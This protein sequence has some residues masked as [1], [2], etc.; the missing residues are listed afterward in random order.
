M[1]ACDT[2]NEGLPRALIR[3]A[4]GPTCGL[5]ACAATFR[6]APRRPAELGE[7]AGE[8]PGPRRR[9]FVGRRVVPSVTRERSCSCRSN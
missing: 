9:I 3:P 7:R 1:G 5:L 6:I 2:A 4:S 8:R